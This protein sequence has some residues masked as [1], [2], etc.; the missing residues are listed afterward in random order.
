LSSVAVVVLGDLARSPRMLAHMRCLARHGRA[1]DLIGYVERPIEVPAGVRV[2][3][4][5]PLP[6]APEGSGT[7]RFIA[8]AGLRMGALHAELGA[9][10][11]RLRPRVILAQNPP[12]FP[13]LSACAL[14]ARVCRAK[15]VVDWHN[16]GHSLLALRLPAAHGVVRLARRYEHGAAKHA[17]AHL[18]VSQAMQ[19]ELSALGITAHVLYDRPAHARPIPQRATDAHGRSL[20]CPTSFTVDEDLPLLLRALSL[21]DAQS[22]EPLEVYITGD[23]PLRRDIE[24]RVGATTLEHVRVH[25]GY[26]PRDEYAALLMRADLGVSLHRS[27]SGVDLAMK[28]VDMF[29]ARLPVCALDYGTSLPEQVQDGE[30]GVLF[31]SAEQLAAQL[32]ALLADPQRIARMRANIETRWRETWAEHW[33]HVAAPL[34]ELERLEL[35]AP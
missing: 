8:A 14:A 22:S 3:A 35:R 15:L 31:R 29:E 34:L 27:S 13:T 5:H 16:Y 17:D 18:C 33:D 11:V 10:L 23:G 21:L 12:S 6:R 2:H 26:F 25:F 28:V 1:V 30:T 19:R 4:L 20:I 32:A 9:L 7:T 24:A